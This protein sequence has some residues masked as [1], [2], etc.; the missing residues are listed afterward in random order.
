MQQQ[1]RDRLQQMRRGDVPD[2]YQQTEVGIV[3]DDMKELP[4][5]ECDMEDHA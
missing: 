1:I 2:G 3:S 5:E 4:I